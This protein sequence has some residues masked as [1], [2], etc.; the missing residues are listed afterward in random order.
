MTASR[1]LDLGRR[2]GMHAPGGSEIA[3]EYGTAVLVVAAALLMLHLPALRGFPF[4]T[5][6]LAVEVT[7]LVGGLG[8]AVLAT[9]LACLGADFFHLPPVNAFGIAS[10]TDQVRLALF[11]VVGVLSALL[12]GSLRAAYQRARAAQWQ[13]EQATRAREEFL[14]IASHELRTPMT[15]LLLAVQALRRGL[16]D[17]SP[18]AVGRAAALSERQAQ[19][20]VR[21]VDD[22]VRSSLIHAGQLQLQCEE[23]NLA[24]LVREAVELR[25]EE[26]ARSRSV[27]RIEASQPVVGRWDRR[28][29]EQAVTNLVTNAIKFGAGSSIEVTVGGEGEVALVAVRDHGIGISPEFLPRLYGRFERGVSPLAF[30]GLGLGL[31]IAREIVT[32]HG[33]SLSA[34]SKL[35]E[36]STF[37]VELPRAVPIHAGAGARA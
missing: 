16:L 4:V 14:A 29:L 25:S 37:V 27:L 6:I 2:A 31:F 8:P 19:R 28:L 1:L 10:P 34:Q 24:A 26:A 33:G 9:L 7:A 18:D 13:A 32:A 35:G 17:R 11:A 20:M 22:M 21:L 36:G 12:V 3:R 15:S 5:L 30:G 23:V